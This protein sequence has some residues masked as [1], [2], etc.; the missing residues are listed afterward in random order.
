MFSAGQYAVDLDAQRAELPGDHWRLEEGLE[1]SQDWP[2]LPRRRPHASDLQVDV[3]RDSP[4]Y[5][6]ITDDTEDTVVEALYDL[7]DW[8]YRQFRPAYQ[9]ET[10]DCAVDEAIA[11][12]EYTFTKDGNRFG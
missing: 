1:G 7:A 8:L 11:V 4:T 2:F 6:S 9:A 12:N 10:S 3:E 5:E